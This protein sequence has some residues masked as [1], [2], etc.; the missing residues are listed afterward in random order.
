MHRSKRLS[1][2]NVPSQGTRGK[3]GSWLTWQYGFLAFH[4]LLG[5]PFN[6]TA[7][8]VVMIMQNGAHAHITSTWMVKYGTR[9]VKEASNRSW[10]ELMCVK[11]GEQHACRDELERQTPESTWNS[12][13]AENVAIDPASQPSENNRPDKALD[14]DDIPRSKSS[15]SITFQAASDKSHSQSNSGTVTAPVRSTG[16]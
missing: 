13:I 7:S 14:Q 16:N 11:C 8:V 12:C 6:A 10:A 2:R 15:S 4:P 9:R 3:P 1:L 5:K